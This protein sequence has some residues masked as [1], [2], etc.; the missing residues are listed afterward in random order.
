MK[1]EADRTRCAG[2]AMCVSVSAKLFAL[3]PEHRRV[4]VLEQ[5]PG[6]QHADDA[7]EAAE[8]CPTQALRLL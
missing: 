8:L 7:E 1:I 5:N 2:T 4:L 3:D 6:T